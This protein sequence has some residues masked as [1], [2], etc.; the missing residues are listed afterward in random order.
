[1]DTFVFTSR[2]DSKISR[3]GDFCAIK[4]QTDDRL[5]L[6][7]ARGVSCLYSI[8]IWMVVTADGSS[9]W[10]YCYYSLSYVI[11]SPLLVDNKVSH[12]F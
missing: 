1:M 9:L 2:S 3:S 7:H 8:I 4:R 12:D 10:G 6:A 5:P 11:M